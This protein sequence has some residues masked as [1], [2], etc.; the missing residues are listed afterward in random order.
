MKSIKQKLILYF[1]TFMALF[2]VLLCVFNYVNV[3]NLLMDSSETQLVTRAQDTSKL[4]DSFVDAQIREMTTLAAVLDTSDPA[5]ASEKLKE[6]AQRLKYNMIIISDLNGIASLPDG[7]TTDISKR[8]YFQKAL[9]GV[10]NISNPII[11][12][13]QGEESKLVLVV[14]VPITVDGK[15]TSVLVGQLNGDFLSSFSNQSIFDKSGYSMLIDEK[16]TVI[17]HID[18]SYVFNTFNPIEDSKKNNSSKEFADIVS[19]A[20]KKATGIHKYEFD[21]EIRYAAFSPI[22]RTSWFVIVC[23]REN[24][25]FA[26]LN[27]YKIF[28]L[29]AAG[30]IIFLIIL[31]T[32]IVGNSISK[33]I[34]QVTSYAE[35]V[36]NLNV[37]EDLPQNL[38]KQKDEIGVLSRS[39]QSLVENLRYFINKVSISAE[40]VKVSSDTLS[41]ITDQTAHASEETARVIEEIS[42]GANEQSEMTQNGADM[43]VNLGKILEKDISL[44][45]ELN[46]SSD[47]VVSLVNNGLEKVKELTE[48]TRQSD[49]AT[50]QIFDGIIKT[51]E[52]S[53]KIGE[54]S[55]VIA[56]IA[57]QTNLLALNAAIEAA[58]A[59]E[60]GKGFSVVA[61]EIR[62]LAEQSSASTKQID[63]VVKELQENS[64]EAVQ[65]MQEVMQI[66]EEQQE[67][68]KATDVKYR[69]IADAI[70]VSVDRISSLNTLSNEME[71]NKINILD[72]MQNLA[73]IAEEN[74]ASTQ[75]VSASVE[76]QTA[77]IEEISNSS[78]KLKQLVDELKQ[79]VVKFKLS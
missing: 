45:S 28:T 33:P 39:F 48:K 15:V 19:K 11:S 13:V 75:E 38:L 53:A 72:I 55:A 18:S 56:S 59:G 9:K 7:K 27:S 4:V 40:D 58:R 79:L 54:A 65:T 20:L 42:R 31:I 1:S 49:L 69:S 43:I 50:K 24:E 30:I 16:G 74:A 37:K 5:A 44:L 14:A 17:S 62:K 61:D 32:Y 8:D 71:Q 46:S 51:N 26:A 68:V 3:S 52:S 29:A 10:A 25:I 2:F 6:E 77:S 12:V 60:H 21:K 35:L 64:N 47:N 36:G 57:E 76:E 73:A 22:E 63:L 23:E 67:S 78:E 70:S 41:D 34:I 66:I